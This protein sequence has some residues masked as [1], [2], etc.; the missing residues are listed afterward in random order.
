LAAFPCAV[1]RLAM[2]TIT[3]SVFASVPIFV[4]PFGYSAILTEPKV[5]YE[6]EFAEI[7]V[8]DSKNVCFSK[9]SRWI[10]FTERTR[11]PL[12]KLSS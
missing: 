8:A 4:V 11:E 1:A 3:A 9:N 6:H 7:M 12:L 5:G 10:R 2:A